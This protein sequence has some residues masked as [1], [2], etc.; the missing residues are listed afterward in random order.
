M[1]IEKIKSYFNKYFLDVVKNQ[2][3]DYKGRASRSQYWYFVLFCV[4]INIPLAI[5]DVVIGVRLF[6]TI[7]S[8]AI[9]CPSVCLGIRRLHDLGKPGWFYFLCLVPVVGP[10]ALLVMFCLKGQNEKNQF[11]EVSKA[12]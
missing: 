4:L 2:Y 6:S 10:I 12:A 7:F 8:I 9:L 1:N 3:N 11:G 5:V